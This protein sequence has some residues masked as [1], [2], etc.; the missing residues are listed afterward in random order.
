VRTKTPAQAEKIIDA[1]THLFGTKHFHEVRM[2]DIALEAE[3]GKG[4][5]YRYFLDKEELYL[6]LLARASRQIVRRLEDEVRHTQGARHRLE[7]VVGAIIA[8]FDERPPLLDLIQRAEV[9]QRPGGT[10]PWQQARDDLTRL[11]K[12]LFG[13]GKAQGEFA[14][15]DPDLAVLMLM[16]GIRSVI[17]FGHRPRAADLARHIVANF[18][19]GASRTPERP[20]T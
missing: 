10:F 8:F 14:I 16:G 15:R 19:Q 2:E 17:R 12:N 5:L 18:L 7:A 11:I 13:E 4:T 9:L 1:A 3:V 20:A 6:A